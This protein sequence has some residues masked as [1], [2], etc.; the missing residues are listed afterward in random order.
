ME[1]RERATTIIRAFDGSLADAE[2]LLAVERATFDESPYTAGQV[3]AMLAE[4]PPRAW[5][6]QADQEVV[7]FV[8]AFL[9]EGLQ[10]ARWEIDLLAVRPAWTDRGLAGRLIRTASDAGKRLA[11]R[12]R[13]VVATDNEPSL[14][15]FARVGFRRQPE[16]RELF[17]C[18]PGTEAP[19][20]RE[21][22][23]VEVRETAD[24]AEAGVWLAGVSPEALHPRLTL[25]LAQEAGRPVGYAAWLDVQTLLYRGAWVESLEASTQAACRALVGAARERAQAAG[26]DELGMLVPQQERDLRAVFRAEGFESLGGF[27]LL[28]AELPLPGLAAGGG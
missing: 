19:A 1:E 10:S 7:G 25:L 21:I 16:V 12:A 23:G 20:D 15:A 2:G 27:Y 8:I 9:V 14:R 6:A 5:L 26:L 22:P 11:S 28:E 4:G 17:V 18:R 24:P 3:Q 13:A